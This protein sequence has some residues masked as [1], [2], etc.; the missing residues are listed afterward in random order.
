MLRMCRNRRSSRLLVAVMAPLAKHE[1]L[2][3]VERVHAGI[4]RA[5]QAGTKAG[6]PISRSPI[7]PRVRAA[8][9]EA[10]AAGNSVR[11]TARGCGV[12]LGSVQR[13]KREMGD[14]EKNRQPK[15]L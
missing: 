15:L 1:R 7:P 14:A 2:R 9:R 12:G 4:A 5:R 3:Y 6:K 13:V 8:I 11:E 10:V